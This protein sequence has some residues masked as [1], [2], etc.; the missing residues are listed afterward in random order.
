[1]RTLTLAVRAAQDPIALTNAIRQEIRGAD[2]ELPFYGV[3]TM[4]ERVSLSLVDRRT[5]MLLALGFA[6]VALLLAAIGIYGMLAYQVNQRRR[7][8]GI[9]LALGA[10]HASI[11]R[12]VLGEGAAIVG[13][14]AAFGLIGA[15]LLRRRCNR[16]STRSARWTRV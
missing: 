11:F 6:A 4:E 10:E 16:S 14:G 5:P 7:E 15:F 2:A 9:R 3:R 1:M 12:M 8:I 13:L